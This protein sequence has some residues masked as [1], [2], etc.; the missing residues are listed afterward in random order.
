[1]KIKLTG[2]ITSKMQEPATECADYFGF[3]HTIHRFA[4]SDGVGQ[5]FF[6]ALWAEKLVNS[7]VSGHKIENF[8]G[9]AQSHWRLDLEKIIDNSKWYVRNEFKKQSPALGTFIGLQLL[10]EEN[11]WVVH[12]LGDSFL[13][14]LSKD[15][16]N[17]DNQ[18]IKISSRTEPIIFDNYPDYYSSTGNHKGKQATIPIPLEEGVF[19]LMTDALAE[20]FLNGKKDAVHELDMLDGNYETFLE[21][22]NK[23]RNSGKLK[24]D[25][26][27][28]LIIRLTEIADPTI[29][30]TDINCVK[31]EDLRDRQNR[32]VEETR[33][34]SAPLNQESSSIPA[35]DV[36]S[37]QNTADLAPEEPQVSDI[38]KNQ[39]EGPDDQNTDSKTSEG[40]Q[41]SIVDK[42]QL[43]NKEEP[44]NIENKDDNEPVLSVE[45]DADPKESENL[46]Y[47][48]LAVIIAWLQRLQKSL[49]RNNAR[50]HLII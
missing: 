6:P 42:A 38:V 15:W 20:W 43:G 10:P 34:E 41:E 39:D 26:T 46:I 45:T 21:F 29:I 4:I 14:F 40:A 2:F 19:Y 22:V 23:E 9:E 11:N 1:M 24:D 33:S 31:L 35:T 36:Q 3:N 8:V 16:N 7:F 13:F 37:F 44:Q 17:F 27:T 25:D 18:V 50:G 5:S 49:S 12:V 48:F 30:Y 28:L 47:S 32:P